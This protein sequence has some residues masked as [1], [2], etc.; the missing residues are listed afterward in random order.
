MPFPDTG[1]RETDQAMNEPKVGDVFTEMYAFWMYVIGRDGERV[2]TAE[3]SASDKEK[4]VFPRDSE[5]VVYPTVDDFKFRFAYG[6]TEG[7]WIRLHTRGFPVENWLEYIE[8]LGDNPD[9]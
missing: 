7:Y 8:Y 9:G 3:G 1:K 4:V 5:V 2:I 6:N